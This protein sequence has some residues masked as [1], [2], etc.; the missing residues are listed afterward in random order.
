MITLKRL[1]F[2]LFLIIAI[3][4]TRGSYAQ[5]NTDSLNARLRYEN[6]LRKKDS[7]IQTAKLRRK[8]DS[9]NRVLRKQQLLRYRDSMR[10]VQVERRRQDSIKREQIK[11]EM[12]AK[13][14]RQDSIL[15]AQREAMKRIVAQRKK[16]ADSLRAI[17]KIRTDSIAKVR[18]EAKRQ[19]DALRKY[20]KS[21]RYRDSVAS[22]RKIRKDSIRE[23]R[24]TKLAKLRAD[25]KHKADSIK[26]ERDKAIAAVKA[27]RKRVMDSITAKRKAI[28][29]SIREVRKAFMDS[30]RVVKNRIKDSLKKK[31]NLDKLVKRKKKS[32][33][34]LLKERADK[35]HARKKGSWTNEKLLKKGWNI[36]R[37]IWQNTV[38]RYNS[39]YN[40]ER[41]YTDALRRFKERYKETFTDQISIYPYDLESGLTAIG[42]DMDTV[43]KKC[44]YDTQIHDPRSKW[45]DN[46][47]LLMGKAFYFKNDYESAITAFQYVVN[48]YKDGDKKKKQKKG[49]KK[50]PELDEVKFDKNNKVRL[51]T[52]EK[53]G[54]LK[55]LAHHP[56]RNQALVWLARAYSKN[57]QFSEAQ[58]LLSILE[59]DK[60]FPDRLR[61]DLYLAMAELNFD[62]ENDLSAI[63][64][65]EKALKQDALSK[66]MRNRASYL[67]AQL[68]AQD[69]NIAKSNQFFTEALKNKP[70]IEMEYFVKLN[71][72][73]NAIQGKGDKKQAIK[74]LESLARSDKFG[75]WQAQTYLSLGQVLQYDDPES[76]INYYNKCLK[77]E[78][79]RALKAAAFLGKGEIYYEQAKYSLAKTAYDSTITFAKQAKPTL[80]KMD[81][82][83][84]RKEVLTSLIKYTDIISRE[85][86]LQTL[87]RKS[88]KEQIATIKKELKRRAKEKREK[89]RAES[90]KL[91]A[92]TLTP[93]KFG[94]NAWYFYNNTTIQQGMVEFKTKWGDRQLTDNWRRSGSAGLNG[95]SILAGGDSTNNSG[96]SLT[97]NAEVKKMLSKLYKT[98]ADF[99]QSD[100]KIKDAYFQLGLIYTSRLQEYET[101]I[102][103][104]EAMN[105]RYDKH[106]QLAATYYSMIL[107]HQ[108]LKQDAKA[109]TYIQ[110]LK[111]EF[112]NTQF[113]KLIDGSN[114][115]EDKV[116][117]QVAV[118]YDTAYQM[119]IRSEYNNALSN[120]TAS[121]SKYP[122]NVLKPKFELVQAKSLAGLKKYD[123]SRV[124]TEN[125]IREYPGTKEQRY[126]QNFLSYLK[127]AS[128]MNPGVLQALNNSD[129]SS[130]TNSLKI[131]KNKKDP[132]AIYTFDKNEEHYYALYL[133]KVD[134]NTIALKA[135]FSDYN[136]IKHGRKKLKT[137]MN[138]INRNSAL[139]SVIKFENADKASRYAKQTRNEPNLF[140]KV[141]GSDFTAIIISKSN[142][143]ELLKTRKV[144]EYLK[145]YKDNY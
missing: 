9:I 41:K 24:E 136:R 117:A 4:A 118:L 27:E 42:G 65:L 13:R 46:L 90:A 47:Y 89:L 69:G 62:Q 103:T 107:S 116:F 115:E 53:R 125:I 135:G 79:N 23:A 98:P 124:V 77:A 10:Q 113:T 133:K 6:E 106:D 132:L 2:S 74:A 36:K 134:G 55:A 85:D 1:A 59:E 119:L 54:G 81:Q 66:K 39:Y 58:S 38:T 137:N 138:L 49:Y 100:K 122:E 43:I 87:S 25:R 128:K 68:Y 139:M 111:N 144:A 57:N 70:P 131:S 110:K 12:L 17:R 140:S 141:N 31:L 80:K 19:R 72:A 105:M 82:I 130:T 3:F 20:K 63:A 121:L 34:E 18:A 5:I 11:A 22:V 29:D 120:A 127:R 104:F 96:E 61:D 112:P 56:I 44:A 143:T 64:P 40:A 101:S 114:K 108:K 126:A 84:L 67:L 95:S 78:N 71:L 37:R 28:N 92:V 76:A 45:F 52:L 99:E 93:G 145:F 21:R 97:R 123:S 14:R 8:Q 142:F 50:L 15:Q 16:T 75:K 88:K 51:A 60:V 129:S 48:E 73:Q 33:T 32:E 83:N 102:Q 7:I 30:V 86:S 26:A 35:I 91:T 109:N 94:K